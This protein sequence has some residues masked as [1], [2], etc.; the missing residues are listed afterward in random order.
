MQSE[1]TQAQIEIQVAQIL[2][3]SA[4]FDQNLTA[5]KALAG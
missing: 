5:C 4:E 3:Y 2:D 1:I